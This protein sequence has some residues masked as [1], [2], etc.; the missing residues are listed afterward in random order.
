MIHDDSVPRYMPH[1]AGHE[2]LSMGLR[3]LNPRY[4]IE[5]DSSLSQ[6]HHHTLE[7]RQQHGDEVFAALP[8]SLTAQRELL[9]LLCEHL[10]QEHAGAYRCEAGGITS[11]A[12]GFH[13]NLPQNDPEPLW[14]ASLLI[15]DDLAIM[16]P[17]SAGYRLTAASLASPSH[18][19]LKD[20]LGLPMRAVHAPIPGLQAHLA[21]R[22]DRFFT[23]LR[24]E[25]PVARFNWALQAD[26]GL[27]HGSARDTAVGR[28]ACLYYR[29]ERQTLRRLPESDAIVFSIRVFLHPLTALSAVPG[30]LEALLAAVDAAP[31]AL[32]IYKGFPFLRDALE[33]YRLKS[34]SENNELRRS[35]G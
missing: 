27:F 24:P 26:P 20:K 32:A 22:I 21:P 31:P 23:G 9:S 33:Q 34:A 19:R 25:R 14:R 35:P 30:A 12:G 10:R 7:M 11:T 1:L 3:P 8:T 13:V 18:W 6:R 15:A 2:L 17:S 29:V 5:T 16:Q 4:W 28:D